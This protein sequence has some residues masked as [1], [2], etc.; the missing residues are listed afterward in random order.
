M[1]PDLDFNSYLDYIPHLYEVCAEFGY[2]NADGRFK[3]NELEI[4]RVRRA[5]DLYC[6]GKDISF[7]AYVKEL[8]DE[9]KQKLA[10]RKKE[11]GRMWTTK[12]L[13]EYLDKTIGDSPAPSPDCPYDPW[14]DEGYDLSPHP[15]KP[16]CSYYDDD[17]D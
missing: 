12:K 17:T 16:D 2:F 6:Q 7:D 13:E 14:N 9:Y 11:L 1:N 10:D 3:N 8:V 4:K 15:G 5:I